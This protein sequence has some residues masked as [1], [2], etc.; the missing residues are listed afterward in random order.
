MT[1]G[2]GGVIVMRS[3]DLPHKLAKIYA[4]VP[5][6]SLP[7]A[8]RKCRLGLRRAHPSVVPRHGRVT[9]RPPS[10][11]ET[12][13]QAHRI[14]AIIGSYYHVGRRDRFLAIGCVHHV[15]LC[16]L[17]VGAGCGLSLEDTTSGEGGCEP[18]SH[19]YHYRLQ[20]RKTHCGKAGEYAE[21]C[22]SVLETR[23][24]RGL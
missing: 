2:S 19:V 23:N 3:N 7:P 8:D 24:S 5:E 21:A 12:E 10:P 11:A 13:R 6:E 15:R 1:T 14:R 17:S 4:N 20:R 16:G 22:L 9:D 18:V